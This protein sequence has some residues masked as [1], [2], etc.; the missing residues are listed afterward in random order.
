MREEILFSLDTPY[1]QSLLVKG[2]YFGN[3]EQKSLAVMG[4][5]RGNEIQ[6][7]YICAQLIQALGELERQGGL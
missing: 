7:M 6:Q 2:W 5:L 4:V 3:P 1:R